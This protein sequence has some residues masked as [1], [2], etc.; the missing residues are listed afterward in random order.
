MDVRSWSLGDVKLRCLWDVH[1]ML[2]VECLN[3]KWVDWMGFLLSEARE[4]WRNKS[5]FL[6]TWG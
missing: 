2:F 1:G 5:E 4:I 3:G 6:G